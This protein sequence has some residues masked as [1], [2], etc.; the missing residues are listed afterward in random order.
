[1]AET[2]QLKYDIVEKGKLFGEGDINNIKERTLNQNR[3]F[4]LIS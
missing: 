4:K 3:T 1:M 2:V